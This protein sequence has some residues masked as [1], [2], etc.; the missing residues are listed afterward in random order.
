M[1]NS[2][3]N[4]HKLIPIPFL[5]IA[6]CSESLSHVDV[7]QHHSHFVQG[8][9]WEPRHSGTSILP[10]LMDNTGWDADVWLCAH[11]WEGGKWGT[12]FL[13]VFCLYCIHNILQLLSIVHLYSQ[14]CG[15]GQLGLCKPN[16]LHNSEK[17]I[18]VWPEQVP[19]V[20]RS[21]RKFCFW[22][23]WIVEFI[24]FSFYSPIHVNFHC[25][26]HCNQNLNQKMLLHV[27]KHSIQS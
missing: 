8:T 22:I 19:Q 14:H 16:L 13:G 18:C 3:A 20:C 23:L 2:R 27:I 24:F 7:S 10:E 6:S 12:F 21:N 11:N 1:I 15:V 25:L 9:K 4:E 5:L 17:Y 26:F